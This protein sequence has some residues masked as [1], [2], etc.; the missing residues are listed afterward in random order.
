MDQVFVDTW[1]EDVFYLYNVCV[2]VLSF[3]CVCVCVCMSFLPESWSCFQ[4]HP[5]GVHQD[6]SC[7]PSETS[8]ELE[9]SPMNG[10]LGRLPPL[11]CD[12]HNHTKSQTH[13]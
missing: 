13:L 3:V 6:S 9:L 10:S 7:R 1:C 11:A 5:Q 2:C 8:P 12:T 4:G